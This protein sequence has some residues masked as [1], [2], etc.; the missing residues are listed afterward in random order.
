MFKV[1]ERWRRLNELYHGWS[2][3]HPKPPLDHDARGM[4]DFI[5]KDSSGTKPDAP[6]RYYW[7]LEDGKRWFNW[8][9]TNLKNAFLGL[10]CDSPEL[11]RWPGLAQL[12]D[13]YRGREWQLDELLDWWPG[14][15]R[16]HLED[17]ECLTC[18]S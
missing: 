11:F 6:D 5:A 2:A 1:T 16:K 3:W 13:D 10:P 4:L 18:C 17:S 7:V 9:R 8:Y 14:G 15:W 12:A